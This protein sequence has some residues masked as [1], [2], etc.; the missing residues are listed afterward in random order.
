MCKHI[1][2]T[3]PNVPGEF[4]KV[5][6]LLQ[7]S[8]I[9]I[10]G[11]LLASE[12]QTGTVN[13]FCDNHRDAFNILSS[14]YKFFCVERE[15]IALSVGPTPG[16]AEPILSCIASYELGLQNSYLA[17][18]ELQKRIFILEFRNDS[19]TEKAVEL[20]KADGFHVLLREEL[21]S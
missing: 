2:L 19:D 17:F 5:V 1:S 21:T 16:E 4:L 10:L 20:L 13:L 15:V 9:N 14:E 11:H 18:S 8:H 12:R 6:K 7:R 3:I